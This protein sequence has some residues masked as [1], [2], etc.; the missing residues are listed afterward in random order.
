MDLKYYT[1]T[2]YQNIYRHKK[3]G[4]YA[5][6][7]SKPIKTS[8]SKID[9]LKIYDIETAKSIR[10][11]YS[12]SSKIETRGTIGVIWDKYMY[13]CINVKKL[14]K[15]T[16]SKKKKLYNK[17]IQHL[18]PKKLLLKIN[19]EDIIDFFSSKSFKNTTDKQ[20]NEVLKQLKAFFNWCK[21]NYIKD[22]PANQIKFIKTPKHIIR[23]WTVENF[24]QFI[25]NIEEDLKSNNLKIKY[26]AYRVYVLSLI[27]MA[28]GDRLGETRSF[29]FE[30]FKRE[31]EL[32]KI[33]NDIDED[34]T[35]STTKTDE[36]RISLVPP[37]LFDEI[38]L[39][40]DF[41]I[42]EMKFK[43]TDDTLLFLNFSTGKVYTDTTLR[44]YFDYYIEKAE[45]PR[46]TM[47][48]LRHSYVA[49][50]LEQGIDLQ[51]ISKNIGHSNLSTTMKYYGG[52]SEQVKKKVARA[53][54]NIFQ[55]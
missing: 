29:S 28:L 25:M 8:I 27:G 4:N 48:E 53:S 22:N 16:I 5:I 21:P 43:V 20:K 33:G 34:G 9:G 41:L 47:Y 3:N 17:Y 15:R 14:R 37:E 18:C 2:R 23:F 45:V 12:N 50:M 54:S 6:D 55:K 19:K 11:S 46:I 49:N 32:V 52:L 31:L 39:F 40:K 7:I 38:D 36:G 26:K 10:D 51:F 42:N 30:N 24:L 13:D 44:K 1:K 35:L